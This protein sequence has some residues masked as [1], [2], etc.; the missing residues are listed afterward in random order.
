MKDF[1]PMKE[2]FFFLEEKRFTLVF[3]VFDRSICQNNHKKR[4]KTRL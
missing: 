1:W 3:D 4:R 2:V